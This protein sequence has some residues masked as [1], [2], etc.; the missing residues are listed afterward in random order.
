MVNKNTFLP[1][2]NLFFLHHENSQNVEFRTVNDLK[3]YHEDKKVPLIFRNVAM[4]KIGSSLRKCI[5]NQS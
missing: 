5:E 3:N 4:L 1:Y 2:G